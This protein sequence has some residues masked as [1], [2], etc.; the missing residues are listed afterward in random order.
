[1]KV[2]LDTNVVMSAIFFGGIPQR[3]L[4]ASL[5]G[6]FELVA[7]AAI[8][9]EYREVC[10]RLHEQHQGVDYLP[11]LAMIEAAATIIEPSTLPAPVCSDPDDDYFIACA[12]SSGAKIIC[13][14]DAHLLNVNGYNGIE[15]LK[16]REFADAYLP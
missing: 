10:I 14:G 13:S 4:A 12:V 3:I 5:E 16:P 6:G 2:V 7:S 15:I 9:K 1:M 11:A 8:L